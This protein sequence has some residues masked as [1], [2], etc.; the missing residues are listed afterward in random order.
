MANVGNIT[1][2]LNPQLVGRR[3]GDNAVEHAKA[4]I[5]RSNAAT[6]RGDVHM[7]RFWARVAHHWERIAML[8]YT[9]SIV[10]SGRELRRRAHAR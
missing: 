1:I 10:A 3:R 7:G 5:A 8:N 2:T 4:A 9:D 6:N